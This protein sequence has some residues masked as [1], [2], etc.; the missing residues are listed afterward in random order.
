MHNLNLLSETS[1]ILKSLLL[2]AL[3][4]SWSFS[5]VQSVQARAI[6]D[7]AD[8]AFN[9]S[10]T[11]QF[12]PPGL[13][14]SDTS[15]QFQSNGVS[16]LF[17]SLGGNPLDAAG[18]GSPGIGVFPAFPNFMGVSITINPPILAIGFAWEELDGCATGAF[19]GA[20]GNEA[21]ST[22]SRPCLVFFGAADLGGITSILLPLSGRTDGFI[23]TRMIFV[24]PTGGPSGKADLELLKTALNPTALHNEPIQFDLDLT[25]SG[26]DTAETVTV[27]DFLD[28]QLTFNSASSGGGFDTV[29]NVVTW[30]P[31]DLAASGNLLLSLNG[32]TPP[33]V[34]A[35]YCGGRIT[36]IAIAGS[37]TVDPDLTNNLSVDSTLFRLSP[38]PTREVCGNGIDDDCDGRFECADSDCFSFCRPSLPV[39]SG[40]DPNCFGGFIELPTANGPILTDFCTTLTPERPDEP[41]NQAPDHRCGIQIGD[42]FIAVAAFCCDPNFDPT[43]LPGQDDCILRD[44]QGRPID[45]NFKETDPPV[46]IAGYG[47][48]EA[49]QTITY[50]VH[51]ENIGD[52]DALNVSIID[53]LDENLDDST[54]VIDDAGTYDPTTRTLVWSDPVLP[55]ATPRAVSFQIDVRAD[56]T[57]GTRVRNVAT[58]IFPNAVPPSRM[59]TKFVEHVV[60]EPDFVMAPDF[61]FLLC[62][63]TFPGS[64]QWKVGL[65]NQG[66]GFAYNVKAS[67]LN[68][69]ASVQVT[70][71]T[72]SFAHP[73]D[74]NPGALA[75]VIPNA[76]TTSTDTVSFT[77]DTPGDPCPTLTWRLEFLNPR[78]GMLAQTL[79]AQP[80]RDN[81][82]VTDAEDNCPDTFNPNQADGDGDGVGDV[83]D[84]AEQ[85]GPFVC[86]KTKSSRGNICGDDSPLHEGADCD[87]EDDCGGTP[88]ETDFCAP[89]KF[90][91]GLQVTLTDQFET[92]IL[93]DVKKPE[94][95]CNPATVDAAVNQDEDTHLEGYRT[96]LAKTDP[97]QPK[98][99]R[100]TDLRITNPFHPN[101]E[102]VVDTLKP[103]RLLVPTAKSLIGPVPEPDPAT[104]E[105]DHFNCYK[106]KVSKGDPKFPKGLQAQVVDQFNQPKLYDLKK[107][108]RLCAPANKNNED[109]NTVM[110]AD[111][112]MC[113]QAKIAKTD[114]KQPKHQK[115][116]N[117]F[118]NNQFG[119]EQ[120]DTRKE[121]ELCVPSTKARP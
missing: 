99:A 39:T 25:N 18:L 89:N 56:A 12:P 45:P 16:F 38:V 32:A 96:K 90:P 53:V 9:G 50:T 1:K 26:P 36:N 91:K 75:T 47:Y 93:F 67:I 65:V 74:P 13:G 118:V 115:V 81:D 8:S 19:A 37:S 112:L 6:F 23:L 101:G 108:T 41:G 114:P 87:D 27:V 73:D 80:D 107:P 49:G 71:G 46:N 58:I 33:S 5:T 113:Y 24:P 119:P 31:A 4:I 21:V 52:A 105:V 120:L 92:D 66:L 83:C 117:I 121:D 57:P 63:E 70:E 10:V 2:L 109:P 14:P 84:T 76:T 69:P 3:T 85:L 103:D 30:T 77:T 55:P 15:F 88:D 64:G 60:P 22:Y 28:P 29:A 82:A 78:G 44:P 98:P 116:R 79:Q 62:T 100:Q 11:E 104:H 34:G 68:P 43:M 17:E 54:I 86:Y 40:G 111:H 48:T 102:L 42:D 72:A 106:V 95:L 51:Y 7:S 94:T 35:A 61:G 59:D 110:H 97:R 20:S